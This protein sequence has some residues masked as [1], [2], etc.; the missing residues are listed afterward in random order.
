MAA[1]RI[2]AL[3]GRNGLLITE[4]KRLTSEMAQH[5]AAV[6]AAR[7]VDAAAQQAV[8]A[9]VEGSGVPAV[10]PQLMTALNSAVVTE[11]EVLCALARMKGGT[12][13]GPDTL[14][15]ELYRSCA[16]LLAPLLSRLFL[17]MLSRLQFPPGFTDGVITCLPKP[18][19]SHDPANYR[20]IT[21]LGT[22]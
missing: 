8:L 7:P 21:L 16:D 22:D 6:S 2:A 19:P 14:P 13:P 4:P 17:A 3:V 10:E 11:A 15:L 9:A 18:G 20:P 12:S 1:T 5:C